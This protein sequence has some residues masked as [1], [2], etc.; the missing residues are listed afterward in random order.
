MSRRVEDRHFAVVQCFAF[1]REYGNLRGYPQVTIY[2]AAMLLF[3]RKVVVLGTPYLNQIRS[4][5][6]TAAVHGIL[7]V[8]VGMVALERH[9]PR[10][11]LLAFQEAAYNMGRAAHQLGLL[12]LAVPLYERALR[13]VARG[14]GWRICTR[15]VHAAD[16]CSRQP[17]V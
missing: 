10:Y 7:A 4:Y 14:S 5:T 11:P 6:T 2:M 9:E 16:M 8:T 12:H 3:V 17:R 1:L 15:T 13:C